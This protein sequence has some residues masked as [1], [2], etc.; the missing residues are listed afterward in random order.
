MLLA[1]F[2]FNIKTIPL[3]FIIKW[4]NPST[5]RHETIFLPLKYPTT[6]LKHEDAFPQPVI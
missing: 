6:I 3:A 4:T 1:I 5:D 2:K